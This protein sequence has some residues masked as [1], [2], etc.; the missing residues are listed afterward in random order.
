MAQSVMDGIESCL[1]A[2]QL[3]CSR[4]ILAFFVSAENTGK[5]DPM[6]ID[7]LIITYKKN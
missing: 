4:N 6:K 5:C 1:K 3:K 2:E 7:R